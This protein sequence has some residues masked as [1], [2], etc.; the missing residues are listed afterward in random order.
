MTPPRSFEKVSASIVSMNKT[1]LKKQIKGFK[2]GFKL[3]F[4]DAFLNGCSQDRL[5]HILLAAVMTKR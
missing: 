3:D 4:T 5:K 2:G 1:Q